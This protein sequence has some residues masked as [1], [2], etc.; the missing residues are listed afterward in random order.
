MK[1]MNE[2]TLELA[3]R[4][5]RLQPSRWKKKYL[6]ESMFSDKVED[7]EEEEEEEEQQQ[8][9]KEEV[10]IQPKGVLRRKVFTGNGKKA[11][12]RRDKNISNN[13]KLLEENKRNEIEEESRLQLQLQLEEE[14]ELQKKELE[15]EQLCETQQSLMREFSTSSPDALT[16]SVAYNIVS[17]AAEESDNCWYSMGNNEIKIKQQKQQTKQPTLSVNMIQEHVGGIPLNKW[18]RNLRLQ[19]ETDNYTDAGALSDV[20][21]ILLQALGCL[22]GLYE[23]PLKTG[24]TPF[25]LT[26]LDLYRDVHVT[27]NYKAPLLI[28]DV[29]GIVF[30]LINSS[31]ILK[32]TGSTAA[33]YPRLHLRNHPHTYPQTNLRN[34]QQRISP[35]SQSIDPDLHSRLHSHLTIPQN[36]NSKALNEIKSNNRKEEHFLPPLSSVCSLIR[37]FTVQFPPL[38]AFLEEKGLAESCFINGLK[39][40]KGLRVLV[41]ELNLAMEASSKLHAANL[42]STLSFNDDNHQEDQQE[43]FFANFLPDIFY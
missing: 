33:S 23:V 3:E 41:E 17:L 10:F 1:S 8:Q 18:L 21:N 36:V 16:R 12:L 32:I 40:L 27:V 25:Y 20:F 31:K 26:G 13:G 42:N 19:F 29:A 35:Q 11:I 5:K 39:D 34:T 38:R 28:Y 4:I 37:G 15:F 24:G 43:S 30:P 9:Q 14:E 7:K 22:W 6:E 2:R